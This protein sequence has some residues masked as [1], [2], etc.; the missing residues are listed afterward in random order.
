MLLAGDVGA[1]KTILATFTSD[2]SPRV[3]TAEATFHS[4]DYPSLEAVIIAFLEAHSAHVRSAAFGVAGPVVGGRAHITNLGWEIDAEVLA[5]AFG[6]PAVVLLN[7][8]EAIATAVPFLEP[9][10]VHTLAE[11]EPRPDGAIAVIAPGTGLG[12][13]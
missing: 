3:P 2:S 11:G 1:T 6:F 10:D 13:A 9:S 5:R 7:D 4:R 8:L 12:E